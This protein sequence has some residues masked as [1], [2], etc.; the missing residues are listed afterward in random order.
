MTST[1]TGTA[2]PTGLVPGTYTID[3]SHSEVGFVA[4]HAMVT[5]VRG[6]FTGVD[7][8]L[9]VGDDVESSSATATIAVA[10]VSTGSPDRDAH[11]TS[12]DFFDAETHPTI[13]F[14]ATGVRSQGDGY[15]LDGDLTIKG[16][17]KPVTLDLEFE[18]VATDPFGN[19]RA[20]FSASTDVDREAWG[21][22]WNAALETGG[23]L[24]SKKIKLQLDV[25]AIKQA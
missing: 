7:G 15:V 12:G 9:T 8:T 24:V 5:K 23:V 21:L 2:L 25:S 6:R 3:P 19:Q 22:T 14:V 11:L 10:S 20:G 16:V 13:S 17:S 4:R 1:S 18:G